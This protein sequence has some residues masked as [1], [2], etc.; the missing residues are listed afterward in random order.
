MRI[1]RAA[2]SRPSLVFTV[3]SLL[4][5]LWSPDQASA[6]SSITTASESSEQQHQDSNH[7][8]N[9]DKNDI[10]DAFSYDVSHG[11]LKSVTNYLDELS[12]IPAEAITILKNFHQYDGL[13]PFGLHAGARDEIMVILFTLIQSFPNL[14]LYFGTELGEYFTYVTHDGAE[15]VYRE[16]GNSGYVPEDPELGKYYD[17]C[18]DR[19]TGERTSCTLKPGEQYIECI[20]NCQP[21]L[22]CGNDKKGIWCPQYE[23][24]T[25][26]AGE[27]LG[28][29]PVTYHCHNKK[30]Q[31]SQT[32]GQVL[33]V[34]PA[35]PE[36]GIHE[37]RYW[38]GSCSLELET[39]GDFAFCAEGDGDNSTQCDATY[40]GMIA[41]ANFDPRLQPW[42]QTTKELQR[43][44]WSEPYKLQDND[45]A[46]ESSSV[47]ITYSEPFYSYQKGRAATFEGVVAVDYTFDEMNAYLVDTFGGVDDLVVV[48]FEAKAPYYVIG[49][50]LTSTNEQG[51]QMVLKEDPT[52]PCPETKSLLKGPEC[53]AVRVRA[54]QLVINNQLNLMASRA[55]EEQVK[56]GFPEGERVMV[57]D[58]EDADHP[59]FFSQTM[60]Y[61]NSGFDWIVLVASTVEQSGTDTVEPGSLIFM[62]LILVAS[63]GTICCMGL[64]YM[65]FRNRKDRVVRYGDYHFTFAFILGC[66]LLNL[67]SFSGLGRNTDEMCMFR[68]WSYSLTF[69]VT[70]APLFA[71][72][73][74]VYKLAGSSSRMRK[75]TYTNNQLALR[76][77]LVVLV[78]IAILTVCSFVDP[79]RATGKMHEVDGL[80]QQ[81]T[82]CKR[83]TNIF[84][85]S[86]IAYFVTIIAFGCVLSFLSRN[87]DS[88][89]GE[90]RQLLFGMYNTALT[91]LVLVV[92]GYAANLTPAAQHMLRAI[93]VF[94]GTGMCCLTF[95]IFYCPRLKLSLTLNMIFFIL[96]SPVLTASIF[97][98]PRVVAYWNPQIHRRSTIH[99]SG[100]DWKVKSSDEHVVDSEELNRRLLKRVEEAQRALSDIT[101][102]RRRPET[103]PA[104]DMSTT[105]MTTMRRD[106]PPPMIETDDDLVVRQM[107]GTPSTE[108]VAMKLMAVQDVLESVSSEIADQLGASHAYETETRSEAESTNDKSSNSITCNIIQR[109][110]EGA[111]SVGPAASSSLR[112]SPTHSNSHS[113]D[114]T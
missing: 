105:T 65:W 35:D 25:V 97:V 101:L 88:R 67:S 113:R 16:P 93:G 87:I 99:E 73:W 5:L 106:A 24:K 77:F 64:L 89:F 54:D 40:T 21:T 114:E 38:L 59:A 72:V 15:A 83:N 84:L 37:P 109:Q 8:S 18:V 95:D 102:L 63:L 34:V 7:A 112:T 36:N 29:V 92:L 68:M 28:Y 4:L 9:K 26:Q 30:G 1:R 13:G 51:L 47:G 96:C 19:K 48:V 76:A 12:H 6:K 80:P 2:W 79:P 100:L 60:S 50:S 98:I 69:S 49:S 61:T 11:I 111:V 108:D 14:K 57:D 71:K 53:I 42:Y 31:L 58:D 81:C 32:P 46:G 107:Y 3:I 52:Q 45:G 75:V 23:I 103:A 20:N 56:R 17:I 44:T 78:E 94:W 22:T 74:R 91:V 90:S 62:A 82:L 33:N 55:V 27:T 110:E 66:V 39:T 41:S 43:A 86:Q 104:L 10:L 85:Y 70:V